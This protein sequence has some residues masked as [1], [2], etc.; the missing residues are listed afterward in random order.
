MGIKEWFSGLKKKSANIPND[1][2]VLFEMNNGYRVMTGGELN[3]FILKFQE[4]IGSLIITHI[5]RMKRALND[6][7]SSDPLDCVIKMK[8]DLKNIVIEKMQLVLRDGESHSRTVTDRKK[9]VLIN[10][11]CLK[12]KLSELKEKYER[13]VGPYIILLGRYVSMAKQNGLKNFIHII[14]C[15][16]ADGGGGITAA[17]MNLSTG[18]F[19]KPDELISDEQMR[20]FGK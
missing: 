5:E 17:Y 19:M 3:N 7:T 13:E 11:T 4:S 15:Y 14:Y 8:D 10:I 2:D 18:L 16:S 20:S 12:C 1:A 6:H 9:T